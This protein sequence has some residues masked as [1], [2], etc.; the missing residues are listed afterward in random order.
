[1]ASHLTL[2]LLVKWV[3][4]ISQLNALLGWDYHY[5]SLE[6]GVALFKLAV[7][8]L[9][10]TGRTLI[11]NMVIFSQLVSFLLHQKTSRPAQTGGWF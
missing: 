8:A 9:Y 11:T 5:S 10:E 7:R 1:M 3:R 4:K 2:R 6:Y